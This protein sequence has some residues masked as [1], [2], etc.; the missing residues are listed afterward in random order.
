MTVESSSNNSKISFNISKLK[1]SEKDH[2]DDIENLL[3]IKENQLKD[4]VYNLKEKV[5]R[6]AF[7]LTYISFFSI[8]QKKAIKNLV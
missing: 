2:R 3:N 8:R 6:Y 5:F 7:N 1:K 4:E